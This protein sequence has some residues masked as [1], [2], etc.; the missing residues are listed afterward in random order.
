MI[1]KIRAKC[2]T[3][4]ERSLTYVKGTS[5]AIDGPY[6]VWPILRPYIKKNQK[7]IESDPNTATLKF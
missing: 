3:G 6:V 4:P 5:L 1:Y 2:E 7:S